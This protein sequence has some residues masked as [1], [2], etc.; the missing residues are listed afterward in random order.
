VKKKLSGFAT[1]N[2]KGSN[3]SFENENISGEFRNFHHD[4]SGA[5]LNSDEN[6]E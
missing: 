2:N 3:H 5:L 6:R 4:I 1:S